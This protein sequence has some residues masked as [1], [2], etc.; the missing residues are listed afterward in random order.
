[1]YFNGYSSSRSSSRYYPVSS[2]SGYPGSRFD[3]DP[4]DQTGYLPTRHGRSERSHRTRNQSP[5]DGTYEGRSTDASRSRHG[6][7]RRT[8]HSSGYG[9]SYISSQNGI[10]RGR[11]STRASTREST[12]YP[13]DSISNTGR[14][15]HR[16]HDTETRRRSV[17]PVSHRSQR[18]SESYASSF[19]SSSS[20]QHSRSSR[21]SRTFDSGLT[22]SYVPSSR[23]GM[24]SEVASDV[25]SSTV[26]HPFAYDDSGRTH[27]WH[28]PPRYQYSESSHHSR[29]SAR[30]SPHS[31]VSHGQASSGT[32]RSV[33]SSRTSP[34]PRPVHRYSPPPTA[35]LQGKITQQFLVYVL[36]HGGC[37]V[38]FGRATSVQLSV[39]EVFGVSCAKH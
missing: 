12:V 38:R 20:Y 25:S 11:S 15:P 14:R 13:T 32:Y 33:A 10:D 16:Q 9:S 3:D 30:P 1:M 19:P 18:A 34:P 5:H 37:C 39:Y 31:R 28:P 8:A 23:R 7:S 36:A 35:V 6:A 21:S 4:S 17:A 29:R 24:A 26:T 22:Y 2:G 27:T